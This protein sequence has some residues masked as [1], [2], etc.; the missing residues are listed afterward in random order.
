MR[1]ALIGMSGTGKSYWSQLLAQN[2]FERFGCDD[3]IGR[4]LARR[5]GLADSS[6]ESIG[7]WM[8]FPF[9]AGFRD[10]EGQ[11]L[12]LEHQVLSFFLDALEGQADQPAPP[13]VIDT[14][15]SVIYLGDALLARLCRMAVV[16]HLTA[17]PTKRQALLT[18]YQ[19][20]PRP[21][22]WQGH[23]QPA[24]G[25]NRAAAL[26]RCYMTLFDDRERRYRR[27]AHLNIELPPPGTNP[28]SCATLLQPI[29]D[30]LKENP[31]VAAP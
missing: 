1:I 31:H 17:A 30:Y 13:C 25:E 23:F 21:V 3:H 18:A 7:Q 10:R 4:R 29:Q 2:G 24:P 14:T 19:T 11:Y 28:V 6:I 26:A 5:L 22:V 9:E 16:V 20:R 15:G 8:G 12:E 27:H